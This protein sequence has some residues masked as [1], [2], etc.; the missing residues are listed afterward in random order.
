MKQD[1]RDSLKRRHIGTAGEERNNG[2]E[3]VGRS[4]NKYRMI[5]LLVLT[6]L[7]LTSV[8]A[9]SSGVQAATR[10]KTTSAAKTTSTTTTAKSTSTTTSTKAASTAAKKAAYSLTRAAAPA[11]LSAVTTEAKLTYDREGAKG[12]EEG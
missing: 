5:V 10:K 3:Q 6:A 1:K 11:E 8:G 7:F 12:R 9:K 4:I 2:M